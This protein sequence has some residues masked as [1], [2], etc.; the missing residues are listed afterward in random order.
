[1]PRYLVYSTAALKWSRKIQ[2]GNCRRRISLLC[3]VWE[4]RSFVSAMHPCLPATIFGQ[5][6]SSQGYHMLLYRP[7][8]CCL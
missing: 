8:F 2:C 3:L 5:K 4:R 7:I 1:M 6:F